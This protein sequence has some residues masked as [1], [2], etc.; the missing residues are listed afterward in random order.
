MLFQT[1]GSVPT[2][3]YKVSS[4]DKVSNSH[5]TSV[6]ILALKSTTASR[7][8]ITMYIINQELFYLKLPLQF[9]LLRAQKVRSEQ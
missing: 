7:R 3:F 9:I 5:G 2:N 1:I 4:T 6:K 8:Y